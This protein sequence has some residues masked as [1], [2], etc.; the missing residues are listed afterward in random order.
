MR[1][2]LDVLPT[3]SCLVVRALP[4]ASTAS[5]AELGVD[6]DRAL[7]RVLRPAVAAVPS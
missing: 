6:L 5:S 3:G 2:R 7:A 4:P 1:S